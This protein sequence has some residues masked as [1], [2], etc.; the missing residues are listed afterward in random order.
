VVFVASIQVLGTRNTVAFAA[1]GL[2]WCLLAPTLAM[3]Q[4]HTE[5]GHSI[6]IAGSRFLLAFAVGPWRTFSNPAGAAGYS[7]GGVVI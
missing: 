1:T 4:H 6:N 2:F 5:V 7:P 3:R